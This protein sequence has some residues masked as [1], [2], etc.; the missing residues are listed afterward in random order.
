MRVHLNEAGVS[1][2]QEF[3]DEGYARDNLVRPRLDR[4]RDLVA[5]GEID[6]IYIQAPDRLASGAKLMLLVEEF[7]QR[8]VELRAVKGQWEDTPEGKLLLHMQGAI[9]EYE[10]TKIAERT[11]RGKLYWAR[12]GAIVGGQAPYG[13]RFVCRSKNERASFA[14]IETD[15]AVVRE[16]YRLATEERLSTRGLARHLEDR[17]IPTPR[18]ANQWSPTSIDRILRN[19]V[20][21]GTFYYQRTESALPS[22][23]LTIDP[24][25]QS[26]K[27]GKKPRPQEDWISIPVPSIID[28]SVWDAAQEQLLQ[29]SIHSPRNN[30]RHRYLLRGLIRCPRCG[31]AYTGH[32]QHGNRGYRCQRQDPGCVLDGQAVSPRCDICSAG[33]RCSLAGDY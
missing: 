7:Q 1:D 30:T 23:R 21:K 3:I 28:E 8:A 25:K 20:Y 33:G 17:C 15:A 9:A 12:Q 26:S 5:Q 11:R 13:Y 22:K 32:F 10:R 29:N 2:W 4:L 24:Y 19:P 31:G 16:M 18:G 6:H 27:T 14:I